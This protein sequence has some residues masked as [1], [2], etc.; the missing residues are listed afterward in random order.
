[1]AASRHRPVHTEI[2]GDFRSLGIALRA[3]PNSR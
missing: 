3:I 2:A 1:M